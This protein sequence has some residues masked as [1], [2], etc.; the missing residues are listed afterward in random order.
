MS[1]YLLDEYARL[2]TTDTRACAGLFSSDAQYL[3]R[4]GSHDLCFRGRADIGNFLQHVPR[5]IAFRAARCEPDG[6]GY[7]GELRLSSADLS[8]RHQHVR[9]HFEGGRFTRFEVL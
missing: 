6:A 4:L 3:A 8:P 7:R 5:Q 1:Q 9:F 2:L